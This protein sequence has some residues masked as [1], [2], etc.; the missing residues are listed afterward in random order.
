MEYD[1]LES[2]LSWEFWELPPEK[3]PYQ[4]VV[5]KHEIISMNIHTQTHTDTEFYGQEKKQ[6]P[7]SFSLHYWFSTLHDLY[8]ETLVMSSKS[9]SVSIILQHKWLQLTKPF[10]T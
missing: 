3:Q 5:L 7:E 2:M 9:N 10:K 8:N 4:A 1:C 6:S